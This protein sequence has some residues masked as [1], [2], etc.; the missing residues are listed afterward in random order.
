MRAL[1]GVGALNSSVLQAAMAAKRLHEGPRGSLSSFPSPSSTHSYAHS[2]P[3]VPHASLSPTTGSPWRATS[4][5]SRA[6]GLVL[7]GQGGA[8]AVH[9]SQLQP[10]HPAGVDSSQD[11]DSFS[12]IMKKLLADINQ[13]LANAQAY[14]PRA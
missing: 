10:D 9:P 14:D 5:T 12:D 7:P 13:G 3:T 2:H 11:S 4:S 8:A 6:Q 1:Q